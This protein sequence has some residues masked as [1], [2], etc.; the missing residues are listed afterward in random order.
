MKILIAE[1]ERI[2]QCNLQRQL[3]KLGHEVIAVNNGAEAWAILKEETIPIVITD[4][5]MPEMN[6][7]EL[8]RNIRQSETEYYTYI[9]ILTGKSDTNDI[10]MGMEVGADDFIS[11]PFDKNELRVRVRA[12]IRVVKLE[13]DLAERNQEISSANDRMKS[14]LEIAARLQQ[15]LLPTSLPTYTNI[16]FA[17]AYHPC[18]ELAG[19]TLNVFHL[20]KEHLALYVVDVS[21]HGLPAALLSVT[22]SRMLNA[23]Q[24]QTSLQKQEVSSP[25]DI[26]TSLNTQFQ[27]DKMDQRY[28]TLIYGVLNLNT[29]LFNYISAG[30]PPIIKISKEGEAEFLSGKNFAIGWFP[31]AEF[32]QESIQLKRND[33][34]Y[35]YSDGINEAMNNKSEQYGDD[36]M[37][38]YILDSRDIS[39]Q[40]SVSG[41]TNE[42]ENWTGSNKFKDDISTLAIEILADKK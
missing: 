11:K 26:A 19:D 13:R 4:W 17:W 31:D 39:L 1:D 14:D 18:E 41:L 35:L 7:L 15:S 30:H 12:G 23:G 5:E 3:E 2:T 8:V 29:L 24:Q 36:R 40:D 42:I 27:M 9:I 37:I 16:D 6:G 34:I 33:R 20:D 25:V 28:F 22:I 38:K 10:V 21:G 32:K